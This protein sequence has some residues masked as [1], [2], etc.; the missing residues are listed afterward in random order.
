MLQMDDATRAHAFGFATGNHMYRHISCGHFLSYID[1]PFMI[2][3]STDDFIAKS[4]DV[5]R[6]DLM[7]NPNCL[8]LETEYGGHQD[9]FGNDQR[10]VFPALICKY[11]RELVVFNHKEEELKNRNQNNGS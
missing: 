1:V 6:V 7:A 5:P 3:N 4:E 9:F 11:F 8:Y 2:I 10:K